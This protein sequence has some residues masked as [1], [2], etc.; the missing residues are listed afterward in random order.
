MTHPGSMNATSETRHFF[1]PFAAC[2]VFAAC[3]TPIQLTPSPPGTCPSLLVDYPS[4]P[5]AAA[6]IEGT[7]GVANN[8]GHLWGT[9]D[10]SGSE[11]RLNVDFVPQMGWP[12][13]ANTKA[14]GFDQFTHK[15]SSSGVIEGRR[16]DY[17]LEYTL[18]AAICDM[19]VTWDT[20]LILALPHGICVANEGT[21]AT[22]RSGGQ[23][24]A[25]L[26][27][28]A[29]SDPTGTMSVTGSGRAALQT[30]IDVELNTMVPRRRIAVSSNTQSNLRKTDYFMGSFNVAQGV[31]A[32]VYVGVAVLIQKMTDG[33]A[34]LELCVTSPSDR[35][36]NRG[37]LSVEGGRGI[38]LGVAMARRNP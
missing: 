18:P 2:L 35:L 4:Q 32:H 36:I 6:A 16:F 17:I 30:A 37:F 20:N 33:W 13:P 15:S 25:K 21:P 14:V 24:A 7:S 1:I 8:N 29:V 19:A 9:I 28:Y 26:D 27:M 11:H 5:T 31:S 12:V 34:C 38:G 23:V 22:C 3:R 10:A